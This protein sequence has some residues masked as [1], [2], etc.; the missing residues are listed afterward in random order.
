MDPETAPKDLQIW[1]FFLW[2]HEVVDVLGL[3]LHLGTG[4][5]QKL[6]IDSWCWTCKSC[7][8]EHHFFRKSSVWKMPLQDFE[9]QKVVVEECWAVRA[10]LGAVSRM[11]WWEVFLKHPTRQLPLQSA[12]IAVRLRSVV[13]VEEGLLNAPVISWQPV[14]RLRDQYSKP[15]NNLA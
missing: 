10:I 14:R 15:S 11:L 8:F 7:F 6:S 5:T 2:S 13:C 3:M 1:S 9:T 4:W 12:E